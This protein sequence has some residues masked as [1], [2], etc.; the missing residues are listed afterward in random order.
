MLGRGYSRGNH[1][2][3]G[4]FSDLSLADLRARSS[5]TVNDVGPGVRTYRGGI[6]EFTALVTVVR[7]LP[8]VA[9]CAMRDA[10]L[11]HPLRLQP[12]TVSF[13]V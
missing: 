8:T 2:R 5:T 9:R 3:G 10:R 1:V 7:D 6:D 13:S 12:G 11:Q 4:A